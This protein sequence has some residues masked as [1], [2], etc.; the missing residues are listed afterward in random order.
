M[1]ADLSDVAVASQDGQVRPQRRR[2]EVERP[3]YLVL[4]DGPVALDVLVDVLAVFVFEV[5][6][7]SY[8]CLLY[9]SLSGL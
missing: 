6:T 8:F 5:E 3:P 7:V 4:A 1:V 9:T 2:L